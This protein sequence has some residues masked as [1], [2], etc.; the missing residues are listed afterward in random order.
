[1]TK[2]TIR[3]L[4]EEL[5][6]QA[7]LA[8]VENRCAVSDILNAALEEWLNATVTTVPIEVDDQK[9]NWSGTDASGLYHD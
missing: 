6:I 9:P 2:I 1:M 7:R 8:A 5:Y 3:N 4:D